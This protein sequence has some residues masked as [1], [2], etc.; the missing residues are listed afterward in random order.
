MRV[1]NV[2]ERKLGAPAATAGELIDKLASENDLLWPRDRWPPMRFDRSLSVGAVGG[3]GPIRYVVEAYEVGGRISFRFTKPERFRGGH[4]FEID[5]L[6]TDRVIL[7]HV[8]EMQTVGGAYLSWL[9]TIRPLHNALIEDALDR[10][11][12]FTGGTPRKRSW[13]LWVKFLRWSM[14]R[15]RLVA[16]RARTG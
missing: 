7:R 8:I 16:E 5:A 1:S 2:H 3:H 4:R 11:E 10:A 6:S 12:L 9:F 13:S 14:T 15:S